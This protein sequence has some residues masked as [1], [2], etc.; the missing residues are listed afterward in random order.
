[1]LG[2][3]HGGVAVGRPGGVALQRRDAL[4]GA[5]ELGA[6]RLQTGV[7]EVGQHHPGAEPVEQPG[8][9]AGDAA[10]GTGEQ[11]DLAAEVEHGFLLAWGGHATVSTILPMWSLLSM[12]RW[13]AAA[14][15]SGKVA[16]MIGLTL[17]WSSSGQTFVS[18]ARAISAFCSTGRARRV[19]PVSVRR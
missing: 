11:Q 3:L 4:A 7:V 6:E 8:D 2:Q 19:E 15:A 18:S 13:A 16:W 1:I 12:R 17:P 10:V 14:S 9:R 5:V